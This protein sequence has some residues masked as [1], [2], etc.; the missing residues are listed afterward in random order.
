MA[1]LLPVKNTQQTLILYADGPLS[2][3]GPSMV[4]KLAYG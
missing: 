4:R 1:D 3:I 2:L